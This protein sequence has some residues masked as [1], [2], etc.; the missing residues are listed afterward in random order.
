METSSDFDD[1]AKYAF[2][3]RERVGILYPYLE[4]WNILIVLLDRNSE[5]VMPY[6]DIK[7]EGLRDV[8][9]AV[10]QDV[11]AISMMEDKPSVIKAE[12]YF[13]REC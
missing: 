1:Y 10:L 4:G 5:E 13:Q 9:R 3:V 6:I 12:S 2:V 7:S 8:L 11:K